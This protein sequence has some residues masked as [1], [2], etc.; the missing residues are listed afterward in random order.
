MNDGLDFYSADTSVFSVSGYNY[1]IKMPVMYSHDVYAW[2]GFSAWGVGTW[3]DRWQ[4]VDW[5]Y[6]DTIDLQWGKPLRRDLD[7]ALK[8]ERG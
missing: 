7:R 2:Q 6:P 1:P 4:A 3:Y 8:R 5:S